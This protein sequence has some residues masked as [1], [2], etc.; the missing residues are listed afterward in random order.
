MDKENLRIITAEP[1]GQN[2]VERLEEVLER[3]RKGEVSSVAIAYVDRDGICTTGWSKPP[4]MGLL[5]GATSALL[6]KLHRS[7]SG[8]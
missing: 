2:V 3:A 1:V 5:V 6:D 4:S 7:W 8:S